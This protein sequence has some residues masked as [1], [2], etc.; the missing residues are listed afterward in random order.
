MRAVPIGY[1]LADMSIRE[2]LKKTAQCGLCGKEYSG[3]YVGSLACAFHPYEAYLA[4]M[5][6]AHYNP[7]LHEAEGCKVCARGHLM[8]ELRPMSGIEQR[9]DVLPSGCVR[10]DHCRNIDTLLERPFYGIPTFY[11]TYLRLHGNGSHVSGLQLDESGGNVLLISEPEQMAMNVQY[12]L[13]GIAHIFTISVIEIYETMAALFQL[14]QLDESLRQ[15]RKGPVGS[16]VSRLPQLRHPHAS[17]KFNMYTR[18]TV[19]AEFVPFYILMRVQQN[20][21]MKLV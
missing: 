21:P 18:E 19:L 8:P 11:S 15:A 14:Q 3:A 6:T 20:E 4:C 1:E 10:I 13:P 16:S 9:D 12:R 2:Q 5:R 7:V 17:R